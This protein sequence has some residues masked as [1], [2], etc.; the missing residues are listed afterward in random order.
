MSNLVN[1]MKEE[2]IPFKVSSGFRPNAVTNNGN[3]S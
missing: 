2:H 1:L 3:S